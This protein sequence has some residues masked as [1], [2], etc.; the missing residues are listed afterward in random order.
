MARTVALVDFASDR[1]L[2]LGKRLMPVSRVIA[3]RFDTGPGCGLGHRARM[4]S[5]AQR[6]E[7]LGWTCD[8]GSIDSGIPA[9]GAALVIDSYRLRADEFEFAGGPVVAVD[10]LDRDLEVELVVEPAPP[11]NPA[12]RRRAARRLAG[13]K[14]ALIEPLGDASDSDPATEP[15]RVVVSLGGTDTDGHGARVAAAIARSSRGVDVIHAPGPWS[16]VQPA[17]G[18]EVRARDDRLLPLL[19]SA[20]VVVCAGGV[21]ML[22]SMMVGRPTVAVETALN[23]RRA[24]QGAVEARAVVS[25]DVHSPDS[26]CRAALSILS[27]PQLGRDLSVRGQE[28]VDGR[29]AERVAAAIDEVIARHT[30]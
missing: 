20:S 14:F 19:G 16:T 29:G 17:V 9:R 30:E 1:A 23:Q 25:A 5:L 26:A 13:F 27:D 24:I 3:L 10:D 2:N 7:Q 12:E 8:A 21:T 22:E 28:L 6:L 4:R 11:L 18:V 15:Q